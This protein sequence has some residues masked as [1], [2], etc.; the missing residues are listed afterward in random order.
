MRTAIFPNI[1]VDEEEIIRSEHEE[2]NGKVDD[3][4]DRKSTAF[5]K[6]YALQHAEIGIDDSMVRRSSMSQ[7]Y[8]ISAVNSLANNA[9]SL[10]DKIRDRNVNRESMSIKSSKRSRMECSVTTHMSNLNITNDSIGM[11]PK[12]DD[13][14]IDAAENGQH[15]IPINTLM[16]K[17]KNLRHN[18]AGSLQR[19]IEQRKADWIAFEEFILPQKETAL[20]YMKNLLFFCIAPSMLLA[21]IL[22]YFY[23]NPPTGRTTPS[24]DGGRAS[25]SWWTL[26]IGVRHPLIWTLARGSEYVF[27]NFLGASSPRFMTFVGPRVGLVL[28]HSKGWPCVLLLYGVFCVQLLYGETNFVKHWFYWCDTKRRLLP[29]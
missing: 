28:A 9:S 3:P 4:N 2:R 22:F 17:A 19:I 29:I 12:K 11:A 14:S 10:L 20:G 27:S 25:I 5:T 23:G 24:N 7:S 16:N 1:S 26:F 8:R 15:Q 6:W 18:A 21:C 13:V